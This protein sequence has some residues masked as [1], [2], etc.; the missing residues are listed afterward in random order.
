MA[1]FNP[2]VLEYLGKLDIGILVLVSI[3]Y[4]NRYY[5]STFFYTHNQMLLT[6]P[7]DLEETLGHPIKDDPNYTELISD[8]LKRVIPFHEMYNRLDEI[9]FSKWSS[10]THAPLVNNQEVEYLDDIVE[11]Q[12]GGSSSVSTS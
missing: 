2:S 7:E 9:N 6:A 8:I 5:E 11:D 10:V 4:D 3:V 12:N 1:K